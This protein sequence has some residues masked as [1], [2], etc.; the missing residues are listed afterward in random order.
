[1]PESPLT[2]KLSDQPKKSLPV[3]MPGTVQSK[4]SA[5]STIELL[6]AQATRQ[7]NPKLMQAALLASRRLLG[8]QL[9]A[10][11]LAEVMGPAANLSSIPTD[12]LPAN[13]AQ[14]IPLDQG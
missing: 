14:Q 12:S 9:T 1:M 11:L 8:P 3:S 5:Q 6:L 4:S 7:K 2:P 13:T 10:L